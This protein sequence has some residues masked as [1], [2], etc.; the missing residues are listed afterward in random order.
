MHGQRLHACAV[1][2]QT[3]VEPIAIS[4]LTNATPRR[5]LAQMSI[6]DSTCTCTINDETI[7]K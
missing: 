6:V 1:A 2:M 3:G 5:S 4:S 7:A